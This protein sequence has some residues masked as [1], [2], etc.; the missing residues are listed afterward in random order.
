MRKII[1]C[2]CFLVWGV[3][4]GSSSLPKTLIIPEATSVR[5][6]DILWDAAC[7]VESHNN[8]LAYCEHENAVGIVQ[9]RPIFLREYENQTGI[10]YEPKDCFDVA[11]SKEV[12]MYFATQIGHRNPEKIMR[13]YNGGPRG[14]K[15]RSTISYW[16][17][18]N[19]ELT[20]LK[21]QAS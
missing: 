7:I 16:N 15:K 5:P 11:V 6:Y 12:F 18:I 3:D 10:H 1:F 4:V 19:K 20:N 21:K 9:I 13:N 17:K 8:P 14:M 2:L